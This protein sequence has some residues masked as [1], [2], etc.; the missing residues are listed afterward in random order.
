MTT[1]NEYL[2]TRYSPPI[3]FTDTADEAERVLLE[4]KKIQERHNDLIDKEI[5]TYLNVGAVNLYKPDA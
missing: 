1:V 5:H 4:F 3:D 2:S